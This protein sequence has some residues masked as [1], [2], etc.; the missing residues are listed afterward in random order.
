MTESDY[1]S[2]FKRNHFFDRPTVLPNGK[3]IT[4]KD[5]LDLWRKV[6][7]E[8][9]VGHKLK[10]LNFHCKGM[11]RQN[12]R[13]VC[14]LFSKTVSI[15]LKKLFP[16]DSAKQSLADFIE[17]LDLSFNLLTSNSYDDP[18][19]SKN[20]LRGDLLT[21]QLES[22]NKLDFFISK[23]KFGGSPR[24]HKGM[25]IAIRGNIELQTHPSEMAI[26]PA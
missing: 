6:N 8:I 1:N 12:V 2:N 21:K 17:V 9:S 19:F 23:S 16:H 7:S 10:H 18:N 22:L 3:K 24:F 13:L 4:K 20:A 5:F 15:I 11:D 25:L 26:V 14:E